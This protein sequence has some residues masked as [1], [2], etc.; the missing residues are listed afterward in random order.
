M[1]RLQKVLAKAGIASRRKAEELILAGRVSVDGEIITQLGFQVKKGAAVFF[2]GKKVNG[3]DKVYY[4]LYKPKKVMSTVSDPQKRKTVMDLLSV[5]QRV[6]PVGRLDYDSSGILL[7]SNDG[8]FTNEMTHP[9]FHL[10]KSYEVS[11][12]TV[13]SLDEI[14]ML[15]AGLTLD[16]GEVVQGIKVKFKNK[17]IEKN[18]SEWIFTLQ[19]GRNR[20]I[21]RMVEKLGHN[22]TRLHRFSFAFLNLNDLRPGLYRRLKPIEVKRL[23]LLASTG[24]DE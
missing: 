6:Y 15:E 11:V 20:Q 17:N 1:E 14:K 16:Q 18:T 22:V 19:E 23:R 7:L 2:D 9:R 4:I 21:R 5:E 8:D 24:K 12:D 13:L 10:N 3:E